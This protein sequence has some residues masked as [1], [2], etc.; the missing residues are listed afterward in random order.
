LNKNQVERVLAINIADNKTTI[1]A[2]Q[3]LHK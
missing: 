1:S 2:N 3:L